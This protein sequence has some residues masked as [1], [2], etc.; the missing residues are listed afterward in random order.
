MTRAPW[1]T[2]RLP[3]VEDGDWT[4]RCTGCGQKID[5][6]QTDLAGRCPAC[7]KLF[8]LEP[9]LFNKPSDGALYPE[10]CYL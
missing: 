3:M 10:E 1:V 8:D 4:T 9:W 2:P 7:W 5:F 6:Y